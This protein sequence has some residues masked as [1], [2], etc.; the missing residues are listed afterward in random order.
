MQ[1]MTKEKEKI[2][3]EI[4]QLNRLTMMKVNVDEFE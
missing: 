1:K 3:K 4:E 2:E